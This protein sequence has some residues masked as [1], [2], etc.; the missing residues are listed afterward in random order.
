MVAHVALYK[1]LPSWGLWV[2]LHEPY[3]ISCQIYP[4]LADPQRYSHQ[5]FQVPKWRVSYT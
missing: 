4:D 2:A 1:G 5:K 3:P